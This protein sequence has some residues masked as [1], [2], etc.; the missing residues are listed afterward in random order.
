MRSPRT[1]RSARGHRRVIGRRLA[2]GG[3]NCGYGTQR[4]K[5]PS[6]QLRLAVGE[7]NC[8]DDTKQCALSSEGRVGKEVRKY[9]IYFPH[10]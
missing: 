4:K 10:T 8:V 3:R 2:V 5:T 9:S 6:R 1:A 7:Q